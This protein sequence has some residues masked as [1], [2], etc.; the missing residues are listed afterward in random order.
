MS[1]L[2][3]LAKGFADVITVKDPEL[4][5]SWNTE[6]GSMGSCKSLQRTFLGCREPEKWQHDG[7][8]PLRWL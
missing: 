8:V 3:Y 4:R 1:M 2:P 5:L 7:G 6:G